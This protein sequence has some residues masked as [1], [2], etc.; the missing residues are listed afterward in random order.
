MVDEYVTISGNSRPDSVPAYRQRRVSI[1]LFSVF[2][3]AIG[4]C[5]CFPQDP[6]KARFHFAPKGGAFTRHDYRNV[7][8]AYPDKKILDI[9][10]E[11]WLAE[12]EVQRGGREYLFIERT[13]LLQSLV[14][15]A[16]YTNPATA[17]LATML[18][19]NVISENGRFLRSLTATDLLLDYKKIFPTQAMPIVDKALAERP[20]HDMARIEWELGI[21][22]LTDREFARGDIWRYSLHTAIDN[23]PKTLSEV[24]FVKIFPGTVTNLSQILSNVP[25]RPVTEVLTFGCT[26]PALLS[27][28][29][30][31]N[32]KA[33]EG[34]P[35]KDFLEWY[36]TGKHLTKRCERQL[37]DPQ[38]LRVYFEHWII[39]T[40]DFRPQGTFV[41]TEH[42]TRRYVYP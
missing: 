19:T 15:G 21:G 39:Q 7:F 16:P 41:Q 12:C 3:L 32:A 17:F 28:F 23:L 27:R 4:I 24:H 9:N 10:A 25:P 14:N 33:L 5:C 11:A 38:T 29:A 22:I 40:V 42:Q 13:K 30:L 8:S 34:P 6:G 36:A 26:E 37:L 1:W 35:V 2:G 31:E 20:L 18:T